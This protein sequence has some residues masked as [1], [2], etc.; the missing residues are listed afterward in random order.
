[1]RKKLTVF[2]LPFTI[3]QQLKTIQSL[4]QVLL[5]KNDEKKELERIQK[6]LKFRVPLNPAQKEFLK[7]IIA[8]YG[9]YVK[10]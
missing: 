2:F 10:S 1:M 4:L 5:L 6:D 9:S 8:K 3:D 7:I